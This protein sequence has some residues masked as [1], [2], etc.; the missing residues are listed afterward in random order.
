MHVLPEATYLGYAVFH[1]SSACDTCI[2]A[3]DRRVVAVFS[4]MVEGITTRGAAPCCQ[5]GGRPD[6]G[7]P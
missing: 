2:P 5:R 1:Q 7:A 4:R 6:T 3:D